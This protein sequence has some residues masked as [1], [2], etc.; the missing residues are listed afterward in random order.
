MADRAGDRNAA[1]GDVTAGAGDRAAPSFAADGANGRG[2]RMSGDA[3]TLC[4]K[5]DNTAPPC[6]AVTSCTTFIV[7]PDTTDGERAREFMMLS[8]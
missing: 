5:G 2:E 4:D 7:A 3:C 1:T 8:V 6:P